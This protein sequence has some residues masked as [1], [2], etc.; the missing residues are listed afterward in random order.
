MPYQQPWLHDLTIALAAPTVALGGGDGQIRRGGVQGVMHCDVRVL[1]RA[2]LRLGGE[3][4]VPVAQALDGANTARFTGIARS[5]GDTG[6]DPTVRVER[7]RR[8]APGRVEE[9]IRIVSFASIPVETEAVLELDSDLSVSEHVKQGR[10]PRP[11]GIATDGGPAAALR[12]GAGEISASIQA[13]GEGVLAAGTGSGSARLSWPVRLAPRGTCTLRWSLR[14]RVEG[15]PLTAA[16]DSSAAIFW[17]GVGVEGDDRRIA[18]LAERSLGD[19]GGLLMAPEGRPGDV[20]AAAGAPWFFTLF[21]RD[22]LWTARL[23]LPFGWR[24][25]AGT[26]RALAALQGTKYEPETMEAPGK[27]P[28]ELRRASALHTEPAGEGELV[29]PPLYYGTVDATPLWVCLLHDAWRAGMPEEQVRDLLPHLRAAVR[30][31]VEDG[32][33]DGDGFLEYLDRTGRGL[34]NQG[35]KDSGDSIRFRDGAIARGPVALC[36]AQ[37]YAHEAARHAADLLDAF[38]LE[39]AGALRDWAAGLEERFRARFWVQDG[40]GPYPALALD[41]DKR[42][43]DSLTSN[44]AHLL[45]TGLLDEEQSARVVER[46]TGPGMDSGYGL[47]TMDRRE[48]G[49]SPLSYHCGTVW[50]HDTAIAIWSMARAGFAQRAAGLVDGLLAAAVRFDYRLPELY[51]GDGPHDAAGVTAYPAACRPQAWAAASIGAIVQCLL[52]LH[53]DV[54]AGAVRVAPAGEDR[55]GALR[56]TGLKAGAEE[57]GVEVSA[58]G[59]VR[60]LDAPPWI[61]APVQTGSSADSTTGN[62]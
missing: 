39:G 45:G 32:D 40:E 53:T 8:V 20:L 5:L 36:E 1:S 43:V 19:L 58:G 38:G 54:P 22:S 13:S 46:L 51:S 14:V 52:G 4:P 17:K 33:E 62:A 55:F 2:E 61:T 35:W 10:P 49:Y 41:G 6:A 29:L 9:E 47:R 25:A 48:G 57:Y 23:M 31:I 15:A 42:P 59:T 18:A 21:G 27:I 11:A 30:W 37:G 3:E 44:I 24:L 28:H 7:T 26:L 56:V 12:W 16:P 34:S 60:L 50:P